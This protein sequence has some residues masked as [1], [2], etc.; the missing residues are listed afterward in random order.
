MPGTNTPDTLTLFRKK[1]WTITGIVALVVCVLL[2][3][4]TA[5]PVLLLILMSALIAILLRGTASYLA[6]KTGMKSWLAMLLT[7]T[8]T[9]ALITGVF[10][11]IGAKLQAQIATFTDKL[12]VMVE[13]AKSEVS[14]MPLGKRLM[15]RVSESQGQGD[16]G[17][18]KTAQVFFSSTFGVAG[19]LYVIF[20]LT[21]FFTATP[22]L[23]VDGMVKLLPDRARKRGRALIEKI[24]A[25]LYKWFVGTLFSMTVV[26]I[27]TGIG[28]SI[29]GVPLALTLALTAGILAFVPNFGPV[30]AMAIAVLVALLEGP[31]TALLVGG[32]YV[33]VQFLESNLITPLIQKKMVEIPPALI[34]AG[35]LLVGLF[36]GGIGLIVAT[37][38]MV[39]LM[40]VVQELWVK[41][42]DERVPVTVS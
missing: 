24:G 31:Q 5:F 10:W 8:V 17:A 41:R 16:S 18:L 30:I 26:A 33:L 15:D 7:I 42:E 20:L 2:I 35:Q 28:L 25:S 13:R 9:L 37:P 14:K 40:V 38:L 1:V 21:L 32:L 19:D 4:K 3:L 36:S 29:I 6:R 34:I 23:Y 22:M 27:L 39:M 12:P 11:F